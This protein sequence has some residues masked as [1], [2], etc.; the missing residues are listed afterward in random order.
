MY[1]STRLA[2][3]MIS[4]K[5]LET[6]HLKAKQKNPVGGVTIYKYYHRNRYFPSFLSSPRRAESMYSFNTLSLSLSLSLHPSISATT[7]LKLFLRH[8]CHCTELMNISVS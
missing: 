3:I 4:K 5:K 8:H 6:I 2:N 1:A 7:F